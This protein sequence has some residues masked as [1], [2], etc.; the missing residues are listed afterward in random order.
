MKEGQ[1]LAEDLGFVIGLDA[2][3]LPRVQTPEAL[4]QLGQNILIH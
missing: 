4:L 3:A 2:Q 1:T